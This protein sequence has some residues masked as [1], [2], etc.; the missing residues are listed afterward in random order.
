MVPRAE[1]A[2]LATFASSA[3]LRWPYQWRYIES[4]KHWASLIE[5]FEISDVEILDSVRYPSGI[6][7]TQKGGTL[8]TESS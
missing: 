6:Y 5:V 4:I 3:E 1:S 8:A 2:H 7:H